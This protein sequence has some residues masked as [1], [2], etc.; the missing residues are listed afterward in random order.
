MNTLK[1][2]ACAA[3]A[4]FAATLG[5]NAQ[6][7]TRA[8]IITKTDINPFFVKMKEG[9]TAE[10]EAKG[11]KL[12]SGAGKTDGDNA[13]QVA[14]MENMIAA[15]AKTILITP[16]DAKAIIP[17]IKKAQAKG[18]MVIALDSPTDPLDATDA[19]F[20]TD[21]APWCGTHF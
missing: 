9:A 17:A 8:C 20:A 6:E 4:L 16:S 21:V 19:L 13:G 10:A 7:P 1:T 18:V 2:T 11:A 3:A 14:A 5:A 12:L 15:G